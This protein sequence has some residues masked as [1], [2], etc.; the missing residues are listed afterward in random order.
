MKIKEMYE[1]SLALFYFIFFVVGG[2]RDYFANFARDIT[3]NVVVM[4]NF[5]F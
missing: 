5:T 1:T 2:T 4:S 3:L